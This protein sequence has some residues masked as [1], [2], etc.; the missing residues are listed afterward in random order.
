MRTMFTW[1]GPSF[2]VLTGTD[3]TYKNHNRVQEIICKQNE[4]S[5]TS[6][7]SAF[8]AKKVLKSEARGEWAGHVKANRRVTSAKQRLSTTVP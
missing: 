1:F 5:L 6:E 7:A 2:L 8:T 3:F 4:R